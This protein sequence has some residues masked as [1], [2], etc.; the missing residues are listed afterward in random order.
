[1]AEERVQRR[2]AAIL[3]ADVVGYSRLMGEDEEGT[4]SK[5]NDCL[6]TTVMPAL[7]AHA[8]RLVKTMGD[9]FLVEFPSVL[10]AVQAAVD[11]QSSWSRRQ[12][13]EPQDRRLELRIG[14]HSG[15]VIVEG[16]D[17]HGDGVNIAARLEGIAEPGGICVSDVVYVGIRKKLAIEFDDLGEQSL[18]NIAEPVQVFRVVF[19]AP[20]QRRTATSDALFRRPAV[21]VLPFENLSG[22]PEEE[23]FADGLTE[24]IITH[25]SKWRAFPVIARNSTFAY[26]G[27]SPDIRQVG[28]ELGARYCQALVPG[29][30]TV[31]TEG[32]GPREGQHQ[33]YAVAGHEILNPPDRRRQC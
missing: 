7:E 6:Q 30:G 19:E 1:M 2:L 33:D 13:S 28:R 29:S 25:L 9:G 16:D 12:E 31:A 22:N 24:D 17:I 10:G 20:D 18:K 23:Y 14:V 4:R 8:G 21:A 11:I 26:K 32:A 15:D 3:A 27:K 5:F